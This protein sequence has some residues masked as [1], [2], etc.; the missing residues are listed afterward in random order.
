MEWVDRMMRPPVHP[1]EVE[2]SRE[3]E[4]DRSLRAASQVC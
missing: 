2:I 1:R 3:V 4:V